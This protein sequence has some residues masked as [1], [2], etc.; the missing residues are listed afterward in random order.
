MLESAFVKYGCFGTKRK[1]GVEL[2]ASAHISKAKMKK[3]IEEADKKHPVRISEGYTQDFNNSFWHIKKDGSCR[4]DEYPYGF[5]V[6]SYVGS[7]IS[8]IESMQTVVS[9]LSN[10]GVK[11]NNNCSVH[12]HAEVADFKPDRLSALVAIWMRFESI[13]AEMVPANRAKSV[14]CRLLTEHFKWFSEKK[15]FTPDLFW[16]HIMPRSDPGHWRQ[17]DGGWRDSDRRL[18]LNITNY[19]H[20][21]INRSDYR[22]NKG[23]YRKTVE[24]RLPEGTFNSRTVGN[25]IKFMLQF[26]QRCKKMAFPE[27]LTCFGLE[28]ALTML[29]LHTPDRMLV[30]SKGLWNLKVWILERLIL[31]SRQEALRK[32]ALSLLNFICEPHKTYELQRPEKKKVGHGKLVELPPPNQPLVQPQEAPIRRRYDEILQEWAHA[33]INLAE[34]DIMQNLRDRLA[35]ARE[36]EQQARNRLG[37]QPV[38][39]N[40]AR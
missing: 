3:C 4:D 33:D 13:L 10:L 17:A 5:E 28:D 19:V 31:H 9:S 35:H 29:G 34:P 14:Y 16:Q 1:F 37:I 7:G 18:S 26:V 20:A 39:E 21:Y 6:C 25:W 27:Q 30:L 22:E 23:R 24:L 15:K 40:R 8:D 32:E 11:P 12:V 2:E 38:V 36:Q